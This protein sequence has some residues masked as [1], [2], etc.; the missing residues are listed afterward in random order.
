[1]NPKTIATVVSVVVLAALRLSP[2][3]QVPFRHITIDDSVKDPWA[4]IVADIDKDGFPDIVIGGRAGPLVWYHYPEWTKAVIAKGG[5]RTVDGEAG[6]ID[7]D[8][9]LDIVMG[10]LIWYENPLPQGKPALAPWTAHQVADH[11]THDVEL[12]DLDRDGR[13]D[14]VT[15]D[16]SDFGTKAGDKVYLWRQERGDKWTHRVIECPHG[17]GL[18][19]GDM[20]RDGDPD[21]VIGGIWF[22]NDGRI[23]EGAWR[24]HKFGDWHPNASVEVA[25]LNADGRPDIVLSPSEL[26]GDWYHLS[27]FEAPADPGQTGWTEHVIVE[28]IE[29]VIHGLAT[30]DF[31]GDGAVDIAA[32]EMHQGEDPDEVVLFLNRNKGA[33]W[34][35]QVLSTKGSHCIQAGDIG[36]DGD[37]DLMGANWSGPYQPVELWENRSG[38]G[39]KGDGDG[40]HVPVRVGAG[41]FERE[42]R[43]VEVPLDFTPLLQKLD[44]TVPGSDLRIR[45]R[46][47]DA[48]GRVIR[49]VVP[50]QFD[51]A[52]DDDA[53]T[54]LRGTLTFMLT[55]PMMAR[56][57]RF[58]QVSFDFERGEA[59]P[60][61]VLVDQVEHEGQ[62]S[63]RIVT[64][65]ATYYY[66]QQGAGFASILD[67]DGRDWLSYNPGDGPVSKS[68][69]GGKYRGLPNMVHPEGCFHPG[70]DRCA[71]RL[72][73][74]GPVKATIASESKDGKWACRWDIFPC[75]ARMTVL[76][77]DHPYWFLYEGTPGG[78]LDEDSDYCVRSDGTKT[79][80]NARWEGDIV[81]P[82]ETA[83]WLY[84][85]D[86]A[87]NRVLYLIHE[88]DDNE[89][90]S[91][92]PMNHEM[93][94]FGFGRKDL[95]KYMTQ[96]PAHFIVG[97]CESTDFK[98]VSRAVASAYHP[99][100]IVIGEPEMRAQMAGR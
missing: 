61:V 59:G 79:L 87:L 73:A 95:N 9:D 53:K 92:W 4:K 35:K 10:G 37:V 75:C 60:S 91:Y 96:V 98:A 99:V 66:H 36:S 85:G 48:A 2:A 47:V 32:S 68:G 83:G 17:E 25:D 38:G 26:K 82:R 51:R 78:K 55:G 21:V 16:Q 97:F 89:V 54:N 15:R 34:D 63:F 64:P 7:G 27:W 72:L 41:D 42:S 76:K 86:G 46:E 12:A 24:A 52:V 23:L 50:V 1:M 43:P 56:T 44:R 39:A 3:A 5:Y 100:S 20:D 88:E 31:N 30:A 70:N 62:K 77:T 58:F 71:S 90:D 45:L 93:T 13:L 40:F 28:R 74:A 18:A 6:D 57:E 67:R 65:Q 33:G 69:S 84:F 29:C 49:E 11:K 8:G 94:V 14:I 80:A 22:E 81:A 19:L